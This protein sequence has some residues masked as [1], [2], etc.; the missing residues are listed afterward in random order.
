[1]L[2]RIT[3]A[4]KVNRTLQYLSTNMNAMQ[5]TQEQISSGK[6]IRVASDNP[7][8]AIQSMNINNDLKKIAQYGKN[9]DNG[10]SFLQHTSSVLT[11][12]EDILLQIKTIAENGASDVTTS[13]ERAAFAFQVDQMLEELIQASNSKYEGKFIFGGTETLSGTTA[14]SAPFNIQM[15]GSTIAGVIQNPKGISGEIKRLVGE[16][17]NVTINITGDSV[18]QPN[19]ATGENDIFETIIK[20]R[21]NLKANDSDSIDRRVRELNNEFDLVVGQNTLAGSKVMRMELV[22]DQLADLHVIQK[23][24]LSSIE[25]T[26]I[27]EAIMRLKT[28]EITFQ[29]TLDT[30]SRILQQSLLDYI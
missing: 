27:A 23:E 16:G 12:I 26:D 13:A 7:I 14:N 9:L 19:G 1:M 4:M 28:Q 3:N 17:K 2:D 10:I 25:D 21:E 22:A 30:S 5:K 18:F 11:Q 15:S 24:H 29:A 20:L 8:G 6:M